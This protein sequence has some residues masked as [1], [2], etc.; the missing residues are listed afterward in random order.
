MRAKPFAALFEAVGACV[1]SD[2]NALL[3][4][5]RSAPAELTFARAVRH[6]CAGILLHGIARMHVHDPGTAE[7]TRLLR[8]YAGAAAMDAQ[9]LREQL[10]KILTIFKEHQIPH[11]LLKGSARLMAADPITEWTHI[12]DIDVF[13]PRDW[14]QH[15]ASALMAAGYRYKCDAATAEGFR[16][17]HQHLAPMLPPHDGKPVEIHVALQPSRLFS[18]PC[19]WHALQM[20]LEEITRSS[21]VLR[22]DAYGR[23]LHMAMHGAGLYR[24]GDAAQIAFE[25]LAE[26]SLYERIA[27]SARNE[28]IQPLPLLSVLLA[29]AQLAGLRVPADSRTWRHLR[30]AIAREDLPRFCRGRMQIADAWFA[31]GIFNGPSM[32]LALPPVQSYD[33]SATGVLKRSRIM[34]GRV[35]A[36]ITGAFLAAGSTRRTLNRIGVLLGAFYAKN[37]RCFRASCRMCA[38][39]RLRPYHRLQRFAASC[40]AQRSADLSG[41]FAHRISALACRFR[42]GQAPHASD[43]TERAHAPAAGAYV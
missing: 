7:L 19:D 39:S 36:G 24:L 41:R 35:F 18:L 13:V 4:A 25:L 5:L 20:H 3:Q 14:A 27:A 21:G 34:T 22:L 15:A 16:R 31:D 29:G 11:A 30:W 10:A 38:G 40:L 9:N 12:Y 33:G 32:R 37:L 28:R 17:H 2:L 6:K 26:P 8:R 23:A 43:A 42:K 1:R